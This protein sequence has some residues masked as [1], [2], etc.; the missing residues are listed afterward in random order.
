MQDTENAAGLTCH[1]A[2]EILLN[3]YCLADK[4]DCQTFLDDLVSMVMLCAE[5]KLG[6]PNVWD[7][8]DFAHAVTGI[9]DTRLWMAHLC[10]YFTEHIDKYK[11][12]DKFT[13]LIKEVPDLAMLIIKKL[14]DPHGETY[15]KSRR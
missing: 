15:L 14:A 12:D 5:T 3:M 1:P 13:T 11:D 7:V 6:S 8:T 2:L 10:G 4:Y 9:M